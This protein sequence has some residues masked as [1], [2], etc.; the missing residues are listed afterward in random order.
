MLQ[1]K[2]PQKASGLTRNAEGA[3]F[4]CLDDFEQDWME[5]KSDFSFINFWAS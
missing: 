1:E 2:K 4:L 3:I 5:D